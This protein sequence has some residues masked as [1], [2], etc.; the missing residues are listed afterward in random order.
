MANHSNL[1]FP[2]GAR[3]AQP[4]WMLARG[5]LGSGRT[6]GVSFQPFPNS[7][8]WWWLISSVCL[9]RTSCPKTTHT[10]RFHSAWPGWAVSLLLVLEINSIVGF[11]ANYLY[12][13]LGYLGKFLYYKT[14]TGWPWENLLK[15]KI[16]VIFRSLL[17]LLDGIPSPG[18]LMFALTL[19]INL[20]FLLL[21]KFNQSNKQSFSQGKN[22]PVMGWILHQAMVIQV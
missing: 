20:S 16:I 12:L 13:V 11:V 21:F 19:A 1:V 14:L 15:K 8:G 5:I 17:I 18:Q 7:S 2:G 10:N 3:I 9:T 4:R 6:R 22:L